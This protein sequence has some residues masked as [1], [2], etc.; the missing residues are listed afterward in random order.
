MF[1]KLDNFRNAKYE[2]ADVK[3]KIQKHLCEQDR[4]TLVRSPDLRLKRDDPGHR[5]NRLKEKRPDF[6]CVVKLHPSAV[7]RVCASLARG[8]M[9]QWFI[10]L[11]PSIIFL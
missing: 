2:A 4:K 8:F 7:R 10:Y 5:R 3:A 11:L 1:S 6:C 9:D